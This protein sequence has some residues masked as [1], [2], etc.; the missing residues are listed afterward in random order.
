VIQILIIRFVIGESSS[1]IDQT[2]SL[3][4]EFVKEQTR[5]TGW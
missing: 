1:N 2:F 4:P 5:S 3:S